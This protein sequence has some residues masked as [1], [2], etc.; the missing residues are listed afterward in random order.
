MI[1]IYYINNEH[2]IANSE[3]ET[4]NGDKLETESDSDESDPANATTSGARPAHEAKV[5]ATP[6][7]RR[8]I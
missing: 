2:G 8:K 7:K 5:V 3:C 4:Q 6:P 1:Y